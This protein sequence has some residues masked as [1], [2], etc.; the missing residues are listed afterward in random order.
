MTDRRKTGSGIQP[1]TI[2]KETDLEMAQRHV[3]GGERR[4]KKQENVVA[5]LKAR[6][7]PSERDE[8]LLLLFEKSRITQAEHLET[9]LADDERAKVRKSHEL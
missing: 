5:M 9:L 6:Q 8:E 7:L 2:K 3:R 4:V 1:Q